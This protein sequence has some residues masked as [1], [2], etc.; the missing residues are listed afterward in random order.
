MITILLQDDGSLDEQAK[1]VPQAVQTTLRKGDAACRWF[2]DRIAILL[3]AINEAGT[4][5]VVRR[6]QRVLTGLGLRN[7]SSLTVMC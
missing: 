6:L 1:T 2:N 3:T 4:G 7:P 5:V